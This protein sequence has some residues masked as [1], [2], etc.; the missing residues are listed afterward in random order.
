MVH[1]AVFPV[2]SKPPAA[3]VVRIS[4][5]ERHELGAAAPLPTKASSPEQ[6]RAEGPME[7]SLK[8]VE[9]IG[10]G[11]TWFAEQLSPCIA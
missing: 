8:L 11:S 1:I 4:K 7:S 6:G 9:H 2:G 5:G 10:S 3:V